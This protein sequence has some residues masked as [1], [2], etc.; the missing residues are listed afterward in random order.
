MK[1]KLIAAVVAVVAVSSL[2]LTPATAAPKQKTVGMVALVATDALNKA[3]IDGATKIAKANGWKV[4]VTDT[5][6]SPAKANSAMIAFATTQKV[7]AIIV[8]AFHSS[9]LGAGLRAAAKAKIPVGSW[10]GELVPGVV[11]TTSSTNAG[12]V[13]AN[14]LLAAMGSKG[15]VLALQYHTGVL[16]YFRGQAFDGIMAAHPQITV[17][18]NEVQIPGQVQSGQA[19]TAAWLA[20]HPAGSEPLAIWGTWDEPGMGAVAALK[21][22][23]RTDVTVV[24]IN[25]GPQA[26]QAVKDGSVKQVVW[27]D[28]VTEGSQIMTGIISSIKAGKKWVSKTVDVKPLLVT[29]SNIAAFLAAHPKAMS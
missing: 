23:G 21:Q 12:V 29:S 13:S 4:K 8:M 20:S 18:N 16:C 19:Y 1:R 27:Q 14:G 28:G 26:L 17:T 7:D 9:A 3:V 10:G 15:A 6:G 24:T 25:G 5:Q 22:A 11:V 2:A